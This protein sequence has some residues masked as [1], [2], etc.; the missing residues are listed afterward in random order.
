MHNNFNDIIIT[1]PN[2]EIGIV[3]L[4]TK[5]AA[6]RTNICDL[7]VGNNFTNFEDVTVGL[8]VPVVMVAVRRIK[9]KDKVGRRGW[10]KFNQERRRH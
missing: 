7:P 4:E 3:L 9:V 1:I 10:V 8:W 6:C 5:N 2:I